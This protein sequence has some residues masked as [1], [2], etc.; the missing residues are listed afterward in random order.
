MTRRRAIR[1][2]VL[3]L[4]IAAVLALGWA[5]VYLYGS[6]ALPWLQN[7]YDLR[8]A[9]LSAGSLGTGASVTIAG[10]KV[11]RVTSIT[12]Q[13]DGAVIGM[14]IEH[15]YGPLPRDTR[16]GVSLRTLVGENYVALYP[17]HAK[18]M[19]PNDGLL[20]PTQ[21]VENVDV[22][23][24]LS[25]LQGGT[26]VRAQKMAEGLGGGLADRGPELN[27]FLAQASGVVTSAAP[28][29]QVLAQDHAQVSQLTDQLGQLSAAIGQRGVDIETI[30]RGA[31][32]T[33]QSIADRD[34]YLAETLQRLPATV[35][36]VRRTTATLSAVTGTA[37]PV[38][39]RLATAVNDLDPSIH[40]LL[41][42]ADEGTRVLDQLGLAA[43]PLES[44]LARLRS[45]SAPAARTLPDLHAV[46]CQTTPAAAYL[47]PYAQEFSTLLQDM[48]SAANFYDA[49][50]H[51]ARLYVTV[52]E[53]S[54]KYFSPQLAAAV[55]ELANLGVIGIHDN[56]A[57]NP[58]PAPGDAG[59]T[60]TA[61]DPAG[62]L[63]DTKPYPRIQAEC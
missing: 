53:D 27:S 57:Y 50:G 46:L 9:T 5:G 43:P 6:G 51:A 8:G 10:I 59:E 13:G 63:S 20:G 54:I 3:T 17:G 48:G 44:T 35:G 47:L 56:L 40:T 25:V 42:A 37:A 31:R 45:I 41:P 60:A 36:Q 30:A 2:D 14:E 22:D 11:G 55:H 26:R 49:N 12:Q 61:S 38:L 32:V 24:I 28:I 21:A 23:Q 29:T 33:F 4:V 58:F 52:G 39:S 19:L 15:K 16:F 1:R 7:W 34:Q 62:F 18:Q